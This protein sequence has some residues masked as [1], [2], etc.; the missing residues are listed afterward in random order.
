MAKTRNLLA[1]VPA[2]VDLYELRDLLD[3]RIGGPGQYDGES[4]S[5][6]YLPQARGACRVV[7]IY[8]KDS[9]STLQRIEPGAAFDEVQWQEILTEVQTSL[10]SGPMKVGRDYCF[11]G[12]RVLGSWRGKKSGVQIL[13]P[14]AG[15]PSAPVETAQH[16]FVLECP[17]QETSEWRL[18][19]HRRLRKVRTAAMLLNV[20]LNTSIRPHWVAQPTSLWVSVPGVDTRRFNFDRLRRWLRFP[21]RPPLP[22]RIEWGQEFFFAPLD[23]VVIDTPSPAAAKPIQEIESDV[24]YGDPL[25]RPWADGLQVPVDLDASLCAYGRLRN[26]PKQKLDRSLYWMQL[27]S[28][29]GFRHMAASFVSMV[30]AIEA[31]VETDGGHEAPCT[32]CGGTVIHRIP[33]PTAAFRNFLATY[34]PG[35]QLNSRRNELYALRSGIVH[36]NTLM[37]LDDERFSVWDPAKNRQIELWS[38]LFGITRIALRNWLNDPSHALSASNSCE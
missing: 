1:E 29:F 23:P 27:A 8:D 28:R 20:L 33:G 17:L 30:S 35:A 9:L 12:R 2:A 15:A 21:P 34:A 16:P 7:L 11:S 3:L 4:R 10:L 6:L 31:L 36:G 18:T 38:E 19:N 22:S 5:R 26:E 32:V 37:E 14:P 24:Y 25:R 13:P